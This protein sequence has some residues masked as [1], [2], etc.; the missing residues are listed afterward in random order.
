VKPFGDPRVISVLRIA[1]GVLFIMAALPK[2]VNPHAFAKAVSNY[3]MLPFV[4]ERLLALLLPP[5]ELV[6][7]VCLVVGVVD[8]GAALLSFILMAVFTVAVGTALARGLDISCGC[9]E[10]EGGAKVGLAKIAENVALTLAALLVWRGD[11][12][13]LSLGAWI[14]RAGDIE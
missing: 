10:T 4:A 8:A 6:V 7:G 2:I 3:H 12:S 13:R 14:R 5:L 1:L 9:F 11:R